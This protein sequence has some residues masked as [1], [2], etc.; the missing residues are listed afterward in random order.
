MQSV[1]AAWL[2]TSL[3]PSP[4]FVAL[5]QTAT[6]LPVF[7]VGL[8]AGALADVIDRRRLLLIT[9]GWMLAVAGVLGAMTAVGAMS[10]WTLLTLTFLL[11]L[12]AAL[13]AP[14]WQAIVPELVGR[15]QLAPAVALNSAGFNLAR[16]IGPAIGGI[17]VAWTGPAAVFLLNAVSFLG[18]LVVIFRWRRQQSETGAPTETIAGAI[19][20]GMRY[21]RHSEPLHAVFLRVGIF[22][23]GASALWALLPV[24]ANQDLKI[25]AGGYGLLLGSI[26]LGAVGGAALLPRLRNSMSVDRLA[27]AATLVFAAA[28]LVL[29]VVQNMILLVATMLAGGI[30][31]IAMTSSLNVGAQT[32]SPAWVRARAL[33][34]YLLV[35]QGAMALGS[36]IWG[37]M[38]EKF[39]DSV[40]LSAAAGLLILS[41]AA[42]IKWKLQTAHTIDVTPAIYWGEPRLVEEP[43]PN[44]GP[45]LVTVDYKVPPDNANHFVSAMQGVRN[46]RRRDGAVRWG[47]FRDS[48]DPEHFIETFTVPSWAEHVRQHAR[49][50]VTD[51]AVEE[52]ALAYQRDGNS[53]VVNHY[54]AARPSEDE[55]D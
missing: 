43:D 7:L 51:Q 15:K 30:A 29:G 50:T 45:V 42:G 48:A 32:A 20:A 41:V 39:G 5:L 19:S 24:V 38:A 21:A 14:A 9:Q 36:F 12:G 37:A 46:L 11:G 26:G 28:T 35:F 1:A 4:L 8:P 23:L 16:A 49:T 22:I 34:V 40:T 53:T 2:M 3:T 10:A 52:H 13:N 27:T 18:V 31:W 25:G 55:E 44:D 17:I 54:I 47:L 6:S 33:G